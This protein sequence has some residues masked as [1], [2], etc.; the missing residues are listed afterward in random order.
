MRRFLKVLFKWV[1]II[2]CIP[3]ILAGVLFIDRTL[4]EHRANALCDAAMQ[5][6]NADEIQALINDTRG[7]GFSIFLKPS[8]T[9]Q[10]DLLTGE[11]Y[12]CII[13]LD[14]QGKP[15]EKEIVYKGL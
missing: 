5:K 2:L 11:C 13:T 1:V 15:A 7:A 8:I 9:V 14:D 10:F 4:A 3:L 6:S 12:V